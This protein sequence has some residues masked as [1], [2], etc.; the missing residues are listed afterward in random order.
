M[1]NSEKG[2]E[3][4]FFELPNENPLTC[5]LICLPRSPSNS[6]YS[7]S[8]FSQKVRNLG[9]M[10]KSTGNKVYYYGYESCDVP[11][12][13]KIIVGD[14]NILMEAYPRC[15]SEFG[16]ID[17][18]EQ[19]ENPEAIDY[20][21]KRWRLGTHYELKKRYKPGDFVFWMLPMVDQ[22]FLY[23]ELKDLPVRH[24]EPGIGYIGAFLPYKVFQ[25]AYIRDFHYGYYHG[26][27]QWYDILDESSQQ[28]RPHGSHAMHTYVDWEDTA[29]LKDVVIPNS[30]DIAL[31]DFKVKKKDYL[32]SLARVL[33]GK[34]IRNAVE[35]AERMGMKL[36]VAGPGDFKQAV[37]KNP[38][39]NV[40][41]VGIV[42]SDERRE[43]LANALAVLSLSDVDE[44]FGGVAIEAL[45]SGTV[46]IV[47]NTG[48]FRD[49]IV[50]GYNGY[51][52]DSRNISAG[53]QAVEK[54]SEINPY[55]LR[56]TGLRFSME[57]CALRHNAYL[58]NIDGELKSDNF[59]KVEELDWNDMTGKIDF[60]KA[61]MVPIDVKENADD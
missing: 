28:A 16:Y 49:T 41:V 56:N 10:L 20:L 50:S 6:Y 5:H 36:I 54:I 18:N 39:S 61:W 34:G 15:K 12:D 57:Q 43:L 13:E 23:D 26:N 37:G 3:N 53:V 25:S 29:L 27:N 60:P 22:R 17:V 4:P 1:L 51:R 48:G 2:V 33:P 52:V 40:E 31:F 55:T 42:G 9:W 35:I 21:E 19:Q 47:A 8:H 38:S 59:E 11:C 30:Y 46:P 14:E 45:L 24:V 7:L 58:Q 32:L 44:T